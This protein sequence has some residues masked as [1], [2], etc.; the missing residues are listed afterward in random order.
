MSVRVIV[1]LIVLLLVSIKGIVSYKKLTAPFKYLTVYILLTLVSECISRY[2]A[3][4]I[5]NSSPPYHV[6]VMIEYAILA[7]IYKLLIDNT[8]VK[9]Y[10]TI[11][12]YVFCITSILNSIFLQKLMVYPTNMLL[13]SYTLLLIDAFILF[14]QMLNHPIEQQLSKQAVF[15]FNTGLLLFC[16]SVFFTIGSYNFHIRHGISNILIN[17]INYYINLLFYILIG[18]AI[19]VNGKRE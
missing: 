9:K 13:I 4:T 15:W 11:S 12:I 16:A 17:N 18:V 5:K 7:S 1:Y 10:I 14:F 19:W 6:F 2:L 8:S 3:V